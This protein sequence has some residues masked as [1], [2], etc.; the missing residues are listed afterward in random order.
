[1][2]AHLRGL[3]EQPFVQR[4]VM[5]ACGSR[6]RRSAAACRWSCRV[7]SRAWSKRRH[8]ACR[9]R[10]RTLTSRM[11]STVSTSEPTTCAAMAIDPQRYSPR[12]SSVTISAE[13]VEN[14]V[15][16]PRNPVVTSSRSFR[17]HDRVPR[18]Q[19]HREA[20]QQAA[21]EVRRERAERQRR[22]QRVEQRPRPQR[23]QAPTRRRT[24]GTIRP[25]AIPHALPAALAAA[26]ARGSADEL[27]D[28]GRAQPD[29]PR[30]ARG[31]CRSCVHTSS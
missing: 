18:H 30:S 26:N 16:P 19:L 25:Q 9:H 11:P 29:L 3:L 27:V 1:M 24:H 14:V 12:S 15:R 4:D 13:K 28:V 31:T 10:Q 7:G 8:A 22:K 23:S 21:D 2:D 17:R 20:H 5:R 6:A